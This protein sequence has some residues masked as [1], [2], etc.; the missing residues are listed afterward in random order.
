MVNTKF[1]LPLEEFFPNPNCWRIPHP[2]AH[3]DPDTEVREDV[4]LNGSQT[5]VCVQ[6]TGRHVT[7]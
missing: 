2:A 7:L 4:D 5:R 6:L 1:H 3:D